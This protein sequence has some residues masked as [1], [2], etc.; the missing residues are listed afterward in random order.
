[1]TEQSALREEVRTVR[2][3]EMKRMLKS[4]MVAETSC[5]RW[6]IPVCVCMCVCVRACMCV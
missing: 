4:L 1:M 6:Q 5:K 2:E 3:D